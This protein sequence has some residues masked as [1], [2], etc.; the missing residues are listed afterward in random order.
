MNRRLVAVLFLLSSLGA[1]FGQTA[2]PPA[3]APSAPIIAGETTLAKARASVSKVVG[4]DSMA[5]YLE[6]YALALP[7]HDAVALCKEFLPKAPTSRR[8]EIAALAGSLAIIAGRCD[9]AALLFSMGAEN[10]PDLRL[11]A[12]RCFLAAGD[13]PEAKRQLSLLP[14]EGLGKSIEAGRQLALSWLY[15]LEGEAEKAF[16]QLKPLAGD[17]EAV[18]AAEK[19]EALF[20]LWMIASTSAIEDFKVSTKGFDVKSIEARLQS[21]FEGSVEAA[22]LSKGVAIKPGAWLLA[23]LLAP[24]NALASERSLADTSQGQKAMEPEAF[25]TKLQVGWFSRKENAQALTAKLAK[26]GFS[27]KTDEQVTQ[28][29][30]PRWAVIVEAA[31]DWSKTQAKLKDLGYE[32]YLLP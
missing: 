4:S 5:I 23:G 12:A 14:S 19:R 3:Q 20:L 18:G 13:Y 10:R 1:T 32:S 16:V 27:V 9:D 6:T 28:D 22:I 17:G 24:G 25:A 21:Q 26:A 2:K 15:L 29:G 30:E 8:A 31:D 7:V 11:K